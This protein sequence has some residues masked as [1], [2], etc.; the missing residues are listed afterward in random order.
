MAKTHE[1]VSFQVEGRG[2]FPLD[3][4][5]YDQCWPAGPEDVAKMGLDREQRTVKLNR[6][7]HHR[8]HGPTFE[9]WR[10]FGWSVVPQS[11]VPL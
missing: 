6:A 1:I 8:L 11:A 4:L 9:R 10:S 3:M 2:S 5:R 7:T